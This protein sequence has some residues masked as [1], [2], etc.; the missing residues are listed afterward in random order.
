M[1][2]SDIERSPPPGVAAQTPSETRKRERV[3]SPP[4][5]KLPAPT[6]WHPKS[7]PSPNSKCTKGNPLPAVTSAK[8]LSDGQAHTNHSSYK[9]LADDPTCSC[10]FITLWHMD[11]PLLLSD[12]WGSIPLQMQIRGMC[13]KG[14][15]C[16]FNLESPQAYPNEAP[17]GV[18]RC[19]ECN[20]D[21]ERAG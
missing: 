19:V 18:Y 1:E 8:T 10:S 21:H 13:F 3:S 12:Y 20:R 6:M 16:P 9:A 15:C 5:A 17:T 11:L 14:L 2:L 4:T 7:P